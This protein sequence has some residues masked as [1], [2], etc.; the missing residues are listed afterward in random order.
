LK[1]DNDIVSKVE[2]V[3]TDEKQIRSWF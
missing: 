2:E 3:L 1:I